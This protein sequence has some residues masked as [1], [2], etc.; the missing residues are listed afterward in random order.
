MTDLVK[1]RDQLKSALEIAFNYIA[2][3]A[4]ESSHINYRAREV[5]NKMREVGFPEEEFRRNREL[6]R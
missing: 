2:D 3:M 5:L 1:E 4:L 6:T